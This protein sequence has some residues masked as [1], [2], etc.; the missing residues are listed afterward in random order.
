MKRSVSIIMS[1]LLAAA[2]SSP[3]WAK[4]GKGGGGGGESQA[5]GL[6]GL[7][8]RVEADE[9]LIATLQ[10]QVATLISEV[11][12]L[13]T[14]VAAL[15]TAVS[16]L[17]TAVTA[18]QTAVTALQTA[19]TDLQGQNNW[20]VVNAAGTVGNHS[21][22]DATVT[23]EHVSTGVYE[24]NFGKDVSGCAYQATLGT[25]PGMVAA[26]GDS[27]ADS[28]G[29]VTVSTFNSAGV[30]TDTAFNLTVTCN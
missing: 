15:Q 5:G 12:T 2:V 6:P 9:A 26:A 24:V 8:D 22:N 16:A 3:A 25:G 21:T 10:T 17:Q 18:L 1:I 13:T 27:D 19:V 20:A 28:T 11:A 7:E 23:A 14:D 30:A 29:D 4:P